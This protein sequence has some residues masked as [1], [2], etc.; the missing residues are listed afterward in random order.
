MGD[1]TMY[2]VYA[3]MFVSVIVGGLYGWLIH[4]YGH[5]VWDAMG[6]GVVIIGFASGIALAAAGYGLL[7]VLAH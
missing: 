2:D 3:A 1:L 4:R 7:V 6:P 5:T